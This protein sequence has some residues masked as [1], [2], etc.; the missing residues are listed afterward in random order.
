MSNPSKLDI[1]SLVLAV[2]VLFTAACSTA[3]IPP[4]SGG[5][6][7]G[8]AFGGG[9]A[10]TSTSTTEATADEESGEPPPSNCDLFEFEFDVNDWNV[11]DLGIFSVG[12]ICY[13][14][15]TIE[16]ED[17]IRV[18]VY[19]PTENN[20]PTE[21]VPLLVF[22]A[23]PQ[24]N[25]GTEHVLSEYDD[26]LSQIADAGVA[27]LAVQRVEAV[28]TEEDPVEHAADGILC[29]LR[30]LTTDPTVHNQAW[31]RGDEALV[32]CQ[33]ALGGHAE[34][35][36]A[37][38]RVSAEANTTYAT[39]LGGYMDGFSPQGLLL[40]APTFDDTH[41][42]PTDR[43]AVPTLVLAGSRDTM[44]EGQP[45]ALYDH[46]PNE[47]SD[48]YFVL[49][50]HV[51][52]WVHGASHFEFG[53]HTS[54]STTRGETVA[55]DIFHRFIRFALGHDDTQRPYVYGEAFDESLADPDFWEGLPP[56]D[57]DD[58]SGGVDCT[59]LSPPCDTVGCAEF[60][61]DCVE[62][63]A[64]RTMYTMTER[65][66]IAL[67]EDGPPF[68]SSIE[69][70]AGTGLA[71]SSLSG[72]NVPSPHETHL[73]AAAWEDEGTVTLDAAGI[74]MLDMTHLSLRTGLVT[75]VADDMGTCES[76]S[77]GHVELEVELRDTMIADGDDGPQLPIRPIVMQDYPPEAV[78]EG[79]GVMQTVRVSLADLCPP[80]GPE[81]G[82]ALSELRFHFPD[83]VATTAVGID[84]I[85][86]V[87]EPGSPTFGATCGMRSGTWICETTNT[88]D[89]VETSCD[90]EP[91]S[92]T[93]P[94][95]SIVTTPL[96]P[97]HVDFDSGF[98]GWLVYTMPGVVADPQD[99]TTA[100]LDYVATLCVRACKQEYANERFVSANCDAT[101][102]FETP[103]LARADEPNDRPFL[104]IPKQY[105]D[106]SGLGFGG[107]PLA[108][109]LTDDCCEAFDEQVCPAAPRRVTVNET[110]L[111]RGQE[112]V[113][114]I[115]GAMK[116]ASSYASAPVD[117]DLEGTLGLSECTEGNDDGPCPFYV[118]SMAFELVDP[119]ELEL[120]CNSVP[121]THELTE[122][123]IRL[124]QPA[125]GM[126]AQDTGEVGFPPGGLVLEGIGVVDEIPFHVVRPIEQSVY[127][128]ISDG[129][130]VVLG[131]GGFQLEFEVPCNGAIAD[132]TVWWDFEGTDLPDGPPIAV[133]DVPSTASCPTDID[134]ESSSEDPDEDIVSE[135]WL[136]DGV[137]I[138]GTM[139][140]IPLTTSHELTLITR[141]ARGAT[142]TATQ[143][144][145]CQ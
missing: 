118:G 12:S 114:T 145:T 80:A 41:P 116:A 2:V 122:L 120:T 98:D 29:G 108:C 81:I 100:E 117:A 9:G 99:P 124:V 40:L 83:L 63:P 103:V 109:D 32:G 52:W 97:P 33:I 131:V 123:E 71:A 106:G 4:G 92:A 107:D 19:A 79:L 46:I 112:R 136:V 141:D 76:S 143:S 133:I 57:G 31:E 66:P 75:S 87:R 13:G 72:T 23:P 95:P 93:C 140:S 6:G 90:T 43:L 5:G 51:L 86:L 8:E 22:G 78:C 101:R 94:S 28:T 91:T 47:A 14:L 137:L 36:E 58:F 102:A 139:T 121:Q 110:Q 144:V 1:V 34:A 69:I 37:A 48:P 10:G 49:A 125:I 27:V 67:F 25:M 38:F 17:E 55:A 128:E 113:V 60:N 11:V 15:G 88:L 59:L 111:E 3:Y 135:R 119:L 30:W 85:E 18:R 68:E 42:V 50:H 96:A 20:W 53:G 64:I 35:A 61:S 142:S 39:E 89:V 45:V 105:R 134:L 126:Q 77:I 54:Q 130:P 7:T 21:A 84:T 24:A 62:Q 74:S 104:R 44:V 127:L 70:L 129:W 82:D 73:L 26:I 56:W 115:A 65:T 132:V 16:F 138:D